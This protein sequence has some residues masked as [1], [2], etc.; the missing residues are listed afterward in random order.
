MP[1]YKVIINEEVL[2]DSTHEIEAADAKE[3]ARIAA[4]RLFD[5]TLPKKKEIRVT[6]RWYD[7]F[8]EDPVKNTMLGELKPAWQFHMDD[9]EGDGID[10]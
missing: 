9:I 1:K 6:D 10:A 3:A 2:E 7:V 4:K 8:A 5:G